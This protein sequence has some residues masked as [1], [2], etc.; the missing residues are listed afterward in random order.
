MHTERIQSHKILI[1]RGKLVD[2]RTGFGYSSYLLPDENSFLLPATSPFNR[3]RFHRP[4]TGVTVDPEGS[5]AGNMVSSV[6]RVE[7]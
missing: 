1:M 5:P 4:K 2:L 7:E 3:G 6:D